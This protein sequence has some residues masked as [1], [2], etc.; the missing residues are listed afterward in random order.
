[1]H[2]VPRVLERRHFILI[3]LLFPLIAPNGRLHIY[4]LVAGLVDDTILPRK[5]FDGKAEKRNIKIFSILVFG[6]VMAHPGWFG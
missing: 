6:V 5:N 2:I 3:N 4:F 1:M